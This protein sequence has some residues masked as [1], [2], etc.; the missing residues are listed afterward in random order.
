MYDLCKIRRIMVDLRAF[1]DQLKAET[2]LSLNEALCICQM[3]QGVVEP[4]VLARELGLSPSRL[5]RIIDSLENRGLLMRTLSHQ[6]RRNVTLTLTAQGSTQVAHL[7]CTKIPI[8]EHI[9]QAIDSLK[10]TIQHQE[11]I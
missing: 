3:E 10:S 5:S 1:E 9:R 6:D 8:P 2:G 7:H 11:R 4:G